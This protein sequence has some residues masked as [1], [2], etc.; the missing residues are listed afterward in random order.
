MRS[1]KTPPAARTRSPLTGIKSAAIFCRA[2]S[3][4]HSIP[5]ALIS[6]APLPFF[7]FCAEHQR[8]KHENNGYVLNT[9]PFEDPA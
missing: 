8:N 1:K 5:E 3:R 6:A 9:Q 7:L 2:S 4:R